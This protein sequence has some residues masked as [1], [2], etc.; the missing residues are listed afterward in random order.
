MLLKRFH[1]VHGVLSLD[2]GGLE[3]IVL[4]LI[5]A[6]NS[7][8]HRVSVICLEKPGSLAGEAERCGANVISLGKPPGRIRATKRK[9]ETV[10]EDL[11]PDV[12]HT[13]QIGA[14]WYL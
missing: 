12:L 5:R 10:I 8:G 2:V 9:A 13:H 6:G 3:R 4:D 1:I 11:R 14:L 7:S